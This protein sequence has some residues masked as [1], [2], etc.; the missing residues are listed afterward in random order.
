MYLFAVL[1]IFPYIAIITGRQQKLRDGCLESLNIFT[2]ILIKTRCAKKHH[3]ID[4][5]ED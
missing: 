1:Q 4:F 2:K 5:D 3:N